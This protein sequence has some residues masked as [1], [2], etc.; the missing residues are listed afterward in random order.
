MVAGGQ[1]TTDLIGIDKLV[2]AD[3][4][5]KAQGTGASAEAPH[6]TGVGALSGLDD[7]TKP[8]IN[9]PKH[10]GEGQC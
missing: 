9:P 2:G 4:S 7:H 6:V 8:V 10:D 5:G 3:G 1:L